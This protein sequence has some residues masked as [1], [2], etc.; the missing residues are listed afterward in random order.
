MAT[1]SVG[2]MGGAMNTTRRE[3]SATLAHTL[4]EW[5]A[6]VLALPAAAQ[7]RRCHGLRPGSMVFNEAIGGGGDGDGGGDGGDVVPSPY[8]HTYVPMRWRWVGSMDL[9]AALLIAA[10]LLLNATICMSI[11]GQGPHRQVSS[12]V[13]CVTCVT[14]VTPSPRLSPTLALAQAIGLSHTHCS[15]T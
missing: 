13:T 1:G 3:P 14:Y 4:G 15:P 12:C 2:W 6:R 8:M 10:A 11:L 7:L 5:R 9:D